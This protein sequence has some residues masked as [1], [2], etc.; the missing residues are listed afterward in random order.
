MFPC[1][2]LIECNE[3]HLLSLISQNHFHLLIHSALDSGDCEEDLSFITHSNLPNGDGGISAGQNAIAGH[4]L[5][6]EL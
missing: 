2:L 5:G 4:M 1:W 3:W 6:D